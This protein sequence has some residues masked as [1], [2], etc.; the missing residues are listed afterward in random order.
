MDLKLTSF[1]FFLFPCRMTRGHE[2][3]LT[4]Q[5][6]RKRGTPRETPTTRS[7]VTTMSVEELRLYIQIPIE[8]SL[9]TS[10]DA[11]TS[12]VGEAGNVVYFTWE[13]FVFG[14]RLPIPSLMQKHL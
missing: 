14:L 12:I 2:E 8:I 6:K 10:D 13:Q 1:S 5:A 7:L 4:N 11:A 9:E 3:V